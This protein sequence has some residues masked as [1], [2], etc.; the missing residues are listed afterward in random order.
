MDQ[1]VPLFWRSSYAQIQDRSSFLAGICEGGDFRIDTSDLDFRTWIVIVRS[2]SG[3]RSPCR[4]T[5]GGAWSRSEKK[6][7]SDLEVIIRELKILFP[8]ESLSIQ[9]ASDHVVGFQSELQCRTLEKHG[10]VIDFVDKSYFIDV[11]NWSLANMSKG[12][13]KKVR[14]WHELGG[15]IREASF[16]ELPLVY[17]IIRAN[18]E[19]LGVTPSISLVELQSLINNFPDDYRIYLGIVKDEFA[20]AALV[21]SNT[22][23]QDYVFFWADVAEFRQLSPVASLCQ[24]LISETRARGKH[25]LDLG[26]AQDKGID[27]P[28]LI[29]FKINLGAVPGDKPAISMLL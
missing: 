18:R 15:Q 16:S 23:F 19:T 25:T 11:N 27:N 10:A 21:I 29:R 4:A 9:L 5:F 12:N 22:S 3:F 6:L 7:I 2:N 17:E 13:R 20:C 8:G 28:G 1:I 24:F 26:T 14:Q